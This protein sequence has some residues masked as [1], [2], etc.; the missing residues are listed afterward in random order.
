MRLSNLA[1]S[2]LPRAKKRG[3]QLVFD[4]EWTQDRIEENKFINYVRGRL[5]ILGKASGIVRTGQF[6]SV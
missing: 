4:T 1:V 6:P 2:A 5:A 3:K